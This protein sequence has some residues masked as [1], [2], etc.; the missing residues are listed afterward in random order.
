MSNKN[1]RPQIPKEIVLKLWALAAG[2]C[3]F[4]GCNKPLWRDGLTW[5]EANLAHIAHIIASSPDGPRG[6]KLLSKQLASDFSNLMLVCLEHHKLI[7]S[8]KYEKKYTVELLRSYKRLH[9]E[10]I[11]IQTSMKEEMKTTILIFKA[12]IG[13]RMVDI[14]FVHSVE[15]AAP[16]FPADEKGILLDYTNFDATTNRNY[17]Q[18][19]RTQIKH[20]VE[21]CLKKPNNITHLSIFAIGSIPLLMYLGKCV[22]NIIPADIYQRHRDTQCWTWKSDK[23]S[24]NFRYILKNR[25]ANSKNK[26]VVIVLSL[27]GK[28][29]LH[30]IRRIITQKSP[31]YEVTI[32]TPSPLFLDSKDKLIQFQKIYRE[33]ITKI[34]E[35]HGSMCQIHLFP[36]VPA[37][38]A[39]SCGKELFP[40]A[41]PPIFVYDHIDT[42]QGFKYALRVN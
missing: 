30:E 38:I 42:K 35:K 1:K 17:W 11:Y 16:K 10:R 41:D 4:L 28:I 36:A 24:K 2:R 39:V 14:P 7:D 19:L 5:Q 6:D 40:K 22:G 25:N 29:H 34:R 21:L 32:E 13:D 3:E 27:S 20:D 9:E 18:Q 15:A 31:C 23:G 37:P 26:K 33:L 8:K 12:K